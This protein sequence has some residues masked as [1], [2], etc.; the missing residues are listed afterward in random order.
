MR[1]EIVMVATHVSKS[2][3]PH[4][5][6]PTHPSTRPHFYTASKRIR[7]TA[8]VSSSLP[9]AAVGSRGLGSTASRHLPMGPTPSGPSRT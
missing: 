2:S 3:Q 5:Y 6:P 7:T 4:P 9:G 1:G 8:V